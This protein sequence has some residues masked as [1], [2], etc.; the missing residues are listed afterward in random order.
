MKAVVTAGCVAAIP[1]FSLQLEQVFFQTKFEGCNA[2]LAALAFG[3][4]F[5]TRS[6]VFTS[7]Q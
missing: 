4:L 3:G 1:Q 7:T 6:I 2:G 5:E